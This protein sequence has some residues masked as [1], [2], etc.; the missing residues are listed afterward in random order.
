MSIHLRSHSGNLGPHVLA[1]DLSPVEE[2]ALFWS[3]A[4]DLRPR[5]AFERLQYLDE[6]TPEQ[7]SGAMKRV[8]LR[9]GPLEMLV[10]RSLSKRGLKYRCNVRGLPGSPDVV[11]TRRRVAVFVDGDFWHGWRFADWRHKLSEKWE[12]KIEDNRRRDSRNRRLLRQQ[13]WK[14]IRLWE[15]Q[16]QRNPKA[17]LRKITK[18]IDAQ[19][20]SGKPVRN[21][22]N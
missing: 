21:N 20:R 1:P 10:R 17:C 16:I 15:H 2:E 5:F 3:K 18:F 22:G 19:S 12:T 4:V 11:F 6:M 7:R 9:D 13:R 8:K 14:V